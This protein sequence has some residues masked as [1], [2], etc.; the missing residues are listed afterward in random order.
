MAME[1]P[2]A[3]ERSRTVCGGAVC[4]QWAREVAALALRRDQAAGGARWTSV[5]SAPTRPADVL[6]GAVKLTTAGFATW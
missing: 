5:D 1:W 3:E 2:V 6:K 4:G